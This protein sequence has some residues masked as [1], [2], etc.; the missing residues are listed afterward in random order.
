MRGI[1]SFPQ[2]IAA[3]SLKARG[4][5]IVR[6]HIGDTASYAGWLEGMDTAFVNMDCE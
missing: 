3:D 2:S 5:E 6:G 1:T 4:V